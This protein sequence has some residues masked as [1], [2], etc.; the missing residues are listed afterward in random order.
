MKRLFV[1]SFLLLFANEILAGTRTDSLYQIARKKLEEGDY[2]GNLKFATAMLEEAEKTGNCGQIANATLKV[3]ASYYYL[4]QRQSA[5]D[6]MHKARKMGL[7]CKIDSLIWMSDRQL[8]A[9]YFENSVD[10]SS[11]FHLKEAERII[12][13]YKGFEAE[14]SYIYAIMG[15][16]LY[17]HFHDKLNGK[18]CFDLA[19]QYAYTANDT[20]RMA[21]A[22]IKQGS[23]YITEQS[24]RKAIPYLKTATELYR[25][26]PLPEGVMYAIY[27]LASAYSECGDAKMTYHLMQE[28]KFMQ[29]SMFRKETAKKTAEYKTLYE[30]EKKERENLQLAKDNALKQL[31]LSKQVRHEQMIIVISIAGLVVLSAV[32][33]VLYY[34]Y[35]QKKKQELDEKIAVQQKLRFKAVIEAEEKERMR[36]ARELHD[37][38][39]QMLS[40]AK[41]NMSAVDSYNDDDAKLMSNAMKLVDDSV[42]EVRTI[43][44]NL[45]PSGLIDKGIAFALTELA[46]K[47]NDAGLMR[48]D[49]TIVDGEQRLPSGVEIAIFRIVQEVVNN[50]IKHSKANRVEVVLDYNTEKVFLS[51]RDNGVGFDTASIEQS[52]GIGWKN[53]FSRVYM[54]NGDIKI[55]SQ[56]GT[57]TSV[58]IEFGI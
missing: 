28:L 38:L 29:D 18:K 51:I 27:I 50:M 20:I 15:E 5:I 46:R 13:K 54:M 2:A 34:R 49:L 37:S 42:K 11:L 25:S 1:I 32:F 58:N 56:P 57:G 23:Y 52:S 17:R 4:Q 22:N 39:G 24:C 36:I 45:M 30:T 55:D 35:R 40:A 16:L 6:L 53:I 33:I 43:S 14:R 31:Q 3:A 26:V 44:H 41:M 9:M 21:F 12:N 48:I 19:M 47:I 10:D 7:Q 8:G